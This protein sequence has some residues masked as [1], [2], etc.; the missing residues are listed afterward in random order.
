MTTGKSLDLALLAPLAAWKRIQKL[1]SAINIPD[2]M[3]TL[4]PTALKKVS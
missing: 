1:M 2:L 4:V 3:F